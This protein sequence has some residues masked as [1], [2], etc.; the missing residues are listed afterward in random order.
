MLT[1][2]TNTNTIAEINTSFNALPFLNLI[3]HV[4]AP[5]LARY[6]ETAI[7]QITN[8][9]LSDDE[10]QLLEAR[11][12]IYFMRE[13]RNSILEGANIIKF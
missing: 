10:C 13:L 9:A 11:E 4:S 12:T 1:A 2:T 3:A 5:E 6:L 7:E 8:Y